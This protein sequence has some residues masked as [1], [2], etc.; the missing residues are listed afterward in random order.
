MNILIFIF[1][2]IAD[3]IIIITAE[4][5]GNNSMNNLLCQSMPNLR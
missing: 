5:L 4:T 1:V 2:V 3:V